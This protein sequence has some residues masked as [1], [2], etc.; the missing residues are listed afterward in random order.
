[1]SD[2]AADERPGL[3]PAA[4][5]MH[6]AALEEIAPPT[7]LLDDRWNVLHVSPTAS[8][9]FQQSA[10][11]LARRVTDLVRSELRD[12]LHVL[13]LRASEQPSMQ[14]SPVQDVRFDDTLRSVTM[15]A[16]RR[17]RP[18]GP[19]HVLLTFLDIGDTAQATPDRDDRG[20]ANGSL[21]TRLRD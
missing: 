9:F 1:M 20:D 5:A 3:A 18:T 16:Q 10:G 2:R 15:L 7:V 19:P 17:P 13:L 6:A 8:R 12:A 14:V 11:P 21:S 4:S